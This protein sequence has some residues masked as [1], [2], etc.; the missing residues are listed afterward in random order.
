[1]PV[2][3]GER[4]RTGR[5]ALRLSQE[6]VARR[7]GVSLNQVNRL[8]RGEIV[9]PHFST[10]AGLAAA[11]DMQIS[12]LVEEPAVPLVKAQAAQDFLA[13]VPSAARRTE[14]LQRAAGILESFV[15]R[16]DAELECLTEKDVY[17]YGKGIET[18]H[19]YQGITKALQKGLMPYAV[20]IT[21]ESSEEVSA[22][23]LAGARRLIAAVKSMDSF[24]ERAQDTERQM[25]PTREGVEQGI[26]EVE[27]FV[28]LERQL[29][30][31]DSTGRL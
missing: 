9:D 2:S 24:V 25:R 18:D 4:V 13:Q 26:A 28:A 22:R 23:E 21:K 8:E 10:L 19:L 14:D 6:E 7:A 17:P 15:R 1:M 11:L 3:I 30:H 16:W 5:K 12:E 27:H 20:W 31:V 29:A